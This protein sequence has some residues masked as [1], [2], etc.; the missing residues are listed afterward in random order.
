MRPIIGVN[1]D[2]LWLCGDVCHSP[3]S[4]SAPRSHGKLRRM[5]TGTGVQSSFRF[6]LHLELQSASTDAVGRAPSNITSKRSG[7]VK[8][9]TA[10][11]M[12][13]FIDDGSHPIRRHQWQRSVGRSYGWQHLEYVWSWRAEYLA[14]EESRELLSTQAFSRVRLSGIWITPPSTPN[15][16]RQQQHAEHTRAVT[17]HKKPVP[18][19]H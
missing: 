4:L 7:N 6:V 12:L 9:G 17:K 10:V 14:P 13:N 3:P 19:I 1:C 5:L 16:P 2:C 11:T 15:S 8:R 18:P